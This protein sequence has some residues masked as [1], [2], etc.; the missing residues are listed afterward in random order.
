MK[1]QHSARQKIRAICKMHSNVVNTRQHH[2]VQQVNLK[3]E[4]NHLGAGGTEI[5][6]TQTKHQIRPLKT[7]H[8]KFC[9]WEGL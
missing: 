5:Y 1:F 4:E 3:H 2:Q 9:T 6:V 8:Y 7:R